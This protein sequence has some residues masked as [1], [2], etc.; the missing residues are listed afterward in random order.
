MRVKFGGRLSYADVDYVINNLWQRGCDEVK[1]FGFES[2]EGLAN[3][4]MAGADE[5]GY[6]LTA[7]DVPV[8]VFGASLEQGTW[9]T[10]FLATEQFSDLGTQA[11]R[12][13]NDFLKKRLK[14]NPGARL[15]LIS[16]CDH[17][18]ATRWFRILGFE[19]MERQGAFTRYKYVRHLN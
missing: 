18:E 14:E 9:F 10:W 16:A 15:E 3:F 13:F 2:T 12:F 6:V 17:S 19:V 4:I 7:D 8:V 5:H 11:T 1:A